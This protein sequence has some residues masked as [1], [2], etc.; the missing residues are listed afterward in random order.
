MSFGSK[1]FA[2][3]CSPRQSLGSK[4]DRQTISDGLEPLG[5]TPTSALVTSLKVCRLYQTDRIRRRVIIF[6]IANFERLRT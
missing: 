6:R 5:I 4:F 3:Q 2:E 1:Q